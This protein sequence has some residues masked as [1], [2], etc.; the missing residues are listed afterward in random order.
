MTRLIDMR[1]NDGSRHFGA[2]PETYDVDSPQWYALRD[3]VGRLAGATLRSFVTDDVTEAWIHFEFRGH[4]FSI[5]NQHG[6]WW[7]FVDDPACPDAILSEVLKHF[8][9]VLLPAVRL[10][11]GT[12]PISPGTFRAVVLEADG[13]ITHHDFSNFDDA[14]KYADDAA[15]EVEDGP[16]FAHVLDEAFR[17]VYRSRR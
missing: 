8:E 3:Q 1:M 16:V 6:E 2:L 15:W 4:E 10:S 13:R 11:R 17:I 14:R 9:W 12:G 7:F 5:N